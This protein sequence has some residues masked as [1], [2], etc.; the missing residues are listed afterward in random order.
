[1]IPPDL[2]VDLWLH[3]RFRIWLTDALWDALLGREN[4]AFA[5][6]V[7]VSFTAID[8]ADLSTHAAHSTRN[9]TITLPSESSQLGEDE[10]P[11]KFRFKIEIAT[12]VSLDAGITLAEFVPAHWPRSPTEWPDDW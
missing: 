11:E 9:G 10:E 12:T 8:P 7:V 1:M 4:P 5:N 2:A 3:H 6:G